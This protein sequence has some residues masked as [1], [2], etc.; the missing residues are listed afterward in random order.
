ME[1]DPAPLNASLTR[2]ATSVGGN[3]E[4]STTYTIPGIL[5][6]IKHEWSRVEKERANWEVERGEFKVGGWWL[7]GGGVGW[8]CRV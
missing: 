6:F 7:G 8:S 5:L 1:S 4:L 2:P 3:P